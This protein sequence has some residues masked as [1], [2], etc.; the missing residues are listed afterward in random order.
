MSSKTKHLPLGAVSAASVESEKIEWLWKDRLPKGK[1]STVAGRPGQGKGLLGASI[2]A[3]LSRRGLTV[4]YSAAEDDHATMTKP[5]LVAAGANLDNI[6]LWTPILPEQLDELAAVVEGQKVDLV[7]LDPFA[8]HLEG[9]SRHGDGVRK[10]TKP[11]DAIARKTGAAFFIVDHMVK[12]RSKNTEPI[13][14]I[15]GTGLAQ[16]ARAVYLFGKHPDNADKRVMVSVKQS[17]REDPD[18]LV[19]ELDEEDFPKIGTIPS[20][21]FTDEVEFDAKRLLDGS[22]DEAPKIGRKPTERAAAA[23]WLT[24]YLG[25]AGEPIKAGQIREDGRAHGIAVKTLDRAA[26][27]MGIVKNPPKGGRNVVWDLPQDVKDALD[28]LAEADKDGEQ[29]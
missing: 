22:A 28:A 23:E 21:L 15:G 17:L 18:A 25:A 12:S 14:A 9:V 19:F 20:L 11:L 27:D 26:A 10:V 8:E 7:I 16:V 24:Q 4:L 3:D 29:S 6:I 1:I 2:A 5:R 13:N